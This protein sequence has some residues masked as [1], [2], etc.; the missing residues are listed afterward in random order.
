M[1]DSGSIT[2]TRNFSDYPRPSLAVDPV[3]L[4]VEDGRL[5]TVLWRRANPPHKGKWALPGVF[6]NEAEGLD[7]AVRRALTS[8][9]NITAQAR[10]EQ[11]FTWNRPARDPRGWVVTVAY[12]LL[13]NINDLQSLTL[14]ENVQLFELQLAS[15]GIE[16]HGAASSS[17]K[18]QV[19]DLSGRIHVP[20]FDHSHILE[21]VVRRLRSVV[22]QCDIALR[23]LPERFS[24]RE[25]Q[26]V[27]EAILGRPLN[28]DS[29]RRRVT[30]T[31]RLVVPSGQTED[32]V[33]HR[34][35]ELYQRAE[36]EDVL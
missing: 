23:V 11:L 2:P 8:K 6:V 9:T 10:P 24:L 22:W 25:M 26:A 15:D 31:Q 17:G 13:L 3:V 32:G 29:F 14:T 21:S 7:G 18:L 34:P 27:Y 30:K 16:R 5:L 12:Y 20:A 4:T 19:C 28:K 35:A 1:E 36:L 33:G